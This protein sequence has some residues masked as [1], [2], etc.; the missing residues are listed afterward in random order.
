[1]SVY[2]S[3][4]SLNEIL[5]KKKPVVSSICIISSE[6]IWNG[7]QWAFENL[8]FPK[9]HIHTVL[10]PDREAAKDWDEIRK[11]LEQFVMYGLD[12]DS[13]VIALGGG[14]VGDTAAFAASIYMRGIP[15]IQIPT[16]LVAQVDSAHGGKTGINFL[17]YKNL[18]GTI[19]APY[20]TVIDSRFLLT[21]SDE[22]VVDGLGEII[23]AG[24]IK[25][26]SI[27]KLLSTEK[28]STLLQSPQL[29]KIIHKAIQVKQ[30][31][32]KKD[33][34]DAG[35]RQM[36]NVGH[37]IGHAV[38]LEQHISHGR[39]VLVGMMKEFA[40]TEALGYTK[41]VVLQSFRSLLVNLG[42]VLDTNIQIKPE[43]IMKDKKISGDCLM[44]PTV[45]T[46]G[47]SCLKK[48]KTATFQEGAASISER[49]SL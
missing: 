47:A 7:S 42:I 20:A 14:T 31:Y 17:T 9:N 2:Y 48:I 23:K 49:N 30:Y 29:E 28:V 4:D 45:I 10:I 26:P 40:I 44:L 36:L 32:V 43:N 24:Y 34:R 39:A 21:L 15:C 3:I 38:E 33:E 12:R 8:V 18:I 27:L 35:D 5:L 37:T 25:D 22:Q 16:T 1:M 6:K 11:I 13:V 41:P 19:V 46:I